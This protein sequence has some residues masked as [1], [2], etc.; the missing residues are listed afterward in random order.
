MLHYRRLERFS[1]ASEGFF[2]NFEALISQKKHI[3]D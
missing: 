2:V 3:L 1:G